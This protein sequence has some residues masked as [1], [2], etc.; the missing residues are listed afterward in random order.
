MHF[1]MNPE[2]SII[3]KTWLC[4]AHAAILQRYLIDCPHRRR[5]V[6]TWEVIAAPHAGGHTGSIVNHRR[7]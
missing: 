5:A 2:S 1:T 3:S 4:M 7:S 6:I